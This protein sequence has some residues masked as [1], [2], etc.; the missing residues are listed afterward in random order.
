MPSNQRITRVGRAVHGNPIYKGLT[1]F[2]G[3]L[4]LTKTALNISREIS[5]NLSEN[6]SELKDSLK[7]CEEENQKLKNL[8]VNLASQERHD[9]KN[10]PGDRASV[11]MAGDEEGNYE[12][13][14]RSPWP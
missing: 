4:K 6:V 11:D 13:V 10:L 5:K 7:L 8:L 3:K 9:L 2:E 12:Q 14:R 1:G